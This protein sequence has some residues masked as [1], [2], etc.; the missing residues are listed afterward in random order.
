LANLSS[1]SFLSFFFLFIYLYASM[2]F[3]SLISFFISS[4]SSCLFFV[5]SRLYIF[6]AFRLFLASSILEAVYRRSS[7]SLSFFYKLFYLFNSVSYSFFLLLNSNLSLSSD[8]DISSSRPNP[9]ASVGSKPLVLIIGIFSS[10]LIYIINSCLF[11]C[12]Y[13]S[14]SFFLFKSSDIS[15]LI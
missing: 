8:T 9:P 11:Y 12:S 10:S 4:N 6:S 7:A 3:L 1:S 2:T 5:S 15:L 13:S 14:S